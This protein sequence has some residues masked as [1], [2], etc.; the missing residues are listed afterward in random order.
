MDADALRLVEVAPW[1]DGE[2]WR[3]FAPSDEFPAPWWEPERRV[4]SIEHWLSVRRHG[5]EVVRCKYTLEQGPLTHKL[6]GSMPHGQ[7]DT[8]AFE[9]AISM[10]R[11]G[12][13]RAALCAIQER[14][15]EQRLTALKDDPTS[16]RFWDGVGGVRHEPTNPFFA[17]VERVTYSA[18]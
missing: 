15:P 10:R 11:R 9:I 6:L 12:L 17:G 13:G 8:L 16:R 14:I 7:L 18:E 3:A 2:Y 4:N 5:V 1:P